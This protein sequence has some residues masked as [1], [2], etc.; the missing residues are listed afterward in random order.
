MTDKYRV[1]AAGSFRLADFDPRDTGGIKC[2]KEAAALMAANL[3]RIDKLQ[4]KLYADRRESVILLFQAMDAAG[5]DG[6]IKAV[7][8]CLSP[9][10][11]TEYSFKAPNS[12]ELSRD[13][14]WRIHQ[15]VPPKGHIAIFNRSHYEDV[16]I[17]RVRRLFERMQLP[18]RTDPELIVQ[19]RYGEIRNFESY[20]YDNGV[21]MVKVFLNLS[22]QEQAKRFLSRLDTQE[23]NW[24]LSVD[25]IEESLLWD[26]YAGAFE[27]AINNTATAD[28]PWYIVPADKKWFCR[29]LVSEIIADA[30]SRM[31]PEFPHL[32]RSQLD[33]IE[34]YR[35]RLKEIAACNKA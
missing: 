27:D 1:S 31:D 9:H 6:T 35:P 30:L 29:Y 15:C 16:L 5:K 21:R 14:L 17:F 24:K 32:T 19:K 4:Q 23:K 26:Q 13:Y 8:G 34:D 22:R 10:G 12:A 7:L 3:S 18:K 33:I 2:R 11:V 25:D 20:L 28:C